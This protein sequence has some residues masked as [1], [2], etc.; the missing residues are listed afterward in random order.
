MREKLALV[1]ENF[2][3]DTFHGIG[4]VFVEVGR[5]VAGSF[6]G[7]PGGQI[8]FESE[9]VNL[10]TPHLPVLAHKRARMFVPTDE[11][12]VERWSLE[13]HCFLDRSVL[14]LM[15]ADRAYALRNRALVATLV[16]REI[17]RE[18]V[19]AAERN[20]TEFLPRVTRFESS[21]VS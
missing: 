11:G 13:L 17:A 4:S 21:W 9:L 6:D 18:Q 19:R 2:I 10:V 5:L 7:A 20:T 15:G 8:A 1:I 14:P 3:V 16:D 12:A